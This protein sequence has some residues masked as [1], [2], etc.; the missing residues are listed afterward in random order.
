MSYF[1][2]FENGEDIELPTELTTNE[3][4]QFCSDIIDKYYDEFDFK[5]R[6]TPLRLEIMA[7][8]ILAGTNKDSEYPHITEYKSK[9]QGYKE[10]T[11]SEFEYKYDKKSRK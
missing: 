2:K 11:F 9:K 3:R 4:V 6:H 1:I 10:I 8:Y 7:N 5:L